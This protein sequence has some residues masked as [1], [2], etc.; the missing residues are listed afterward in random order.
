MNTG[1]I[2]Y[3]FNSLKIL[4]CILISFSGMAGCAS[5]N[6]QFSPAKPHH[7]PESFKNNGIDRVTKSPGDLPR[8][9]YQRLRR[10]WPKVPQTPTPAVAPDTA[11]IQDLKAR[12]SLS[13][14]WGTFGL[15][16]ELLDHPP[17]DLSLALQARGVPEGD[18]TVLAMGETLTLSPRRAP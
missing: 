1:V 4:F 17:N 8:W 18:F 10:G 6:A 3:F 15:T 14:H 11:F 2:S 16:D 12:R 7:T 13:V 5:V 9:Q